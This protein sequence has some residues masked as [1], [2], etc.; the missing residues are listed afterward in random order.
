MQIMHVM[1]WSKKWNND[2]NKLFFKTK[3]KKKKYFEVRYEMFSL[4]NYMKKNIQTKQITSYKYEN[5]K[6]LT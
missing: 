1:H 6:F 2:G 5:K 3:L 4:Q